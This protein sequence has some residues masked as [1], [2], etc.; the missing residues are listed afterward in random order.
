[1][2]NK[3]YVENYQRSHGKLI[4]PFERYK[5]IIDTTGINDIEINYQEV[6]NSNLDIND[7]LYYGLPINNEEYKRIKRLVK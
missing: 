5:K 2:W 1:M 6:M 4:S 3:K 7:R